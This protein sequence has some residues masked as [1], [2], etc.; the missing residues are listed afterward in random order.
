MAVID[1]VI[2][3]WER[4]DGEVYLVIGVLALKHGHIG[5]LAGGKEHCGVVLSGF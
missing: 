5:H 4:S 3:C 1:A 2:T